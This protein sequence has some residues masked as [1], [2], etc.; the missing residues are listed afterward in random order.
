M[1]DHILA[2]VLKELLIA[3][4]GEDLELIWVPLLSVDLLDYVLARLELMEV[5]CSAG[6]ADKDCMSQFKVSRLVSQAINAVCIEGIL[7]NAL[8][9]ISLQLR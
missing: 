3:G 6:T 5:H 2:A 9:Q 4:D 7:S 1:F 8:F